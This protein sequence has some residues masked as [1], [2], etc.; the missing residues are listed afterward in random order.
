[1]RDG[2][3]HRTCGMDGVTAIGMGDRRTSRMSH[4]RGRSRYRVRG[5]D[6][7]L[8]GL[9]DMRAGFSLAIIDHRVQSFSVQVHYRYSH[10][11]SHEHVVL[12]LLG[13]TALPP[14][15]T[16]SRSLLLSLTSHRTS[17]RHDRFTP[18]VKPY[19]HALLALTHS[20]PFPSAPR[21]HSPAT[22]QLSLSSKS[23]N[24]NVQSWRHAA[25]RRHVPAA[26]VPPLFMQSP[27]A[28]PQL[29]GACA[30]E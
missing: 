22:M 16:A 1:M 13:C 18:A 9:I 23:A 6:E 15:L 28:N 20:A 4:V 24:G 10:L 30:R 5:W 2:H 14:S 8:S 7:F 17:R 25:P 12:I 26:A 3:G 11:S 21:C 27:A 29:G 19:V